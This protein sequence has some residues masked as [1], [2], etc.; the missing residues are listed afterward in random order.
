MTPAVPT[1][2]L[3]NRAFLTP[4]CEGL[5]EGMVNAR[6]RKIDKGSRIRATL[7]S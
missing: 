5:E 3:F 4:F 1:P 2:A 6:A 7:A